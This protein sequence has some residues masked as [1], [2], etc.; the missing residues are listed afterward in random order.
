[1]HDRLAIDPLARSPARSGRKAGLLRVCRAP[2]L[3][4]ARHAITLLDRRSSRRYRKATDGGFRHARPSSRP[5]LGQFLYPSARHVLQA[6]LVANPILMP[7]L[8][9]PRQAGRLAVGPGRTKLNPQNMAGS[10]RTWRMRCNCRL[11]ISELRCLHIENSDQT[12]NDL[13]MFA[14]SETAFPHRPR[15]QPVR[16]R[17]I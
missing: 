2:G 15:P 17:P 14:S 11:S 12:V 9:S 6:S 1:M 7:A 3:A 5:S 13:G 10:P 4:S 16:P 8:I